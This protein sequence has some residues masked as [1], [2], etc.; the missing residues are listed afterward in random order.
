MTNSSV[1]RRQRNE[2]VTFTLQVMCEREDCD[3]IMGDVSQAAANTDGSIQ[4]EVIQGP[5]PLTNSDWS[6]IDEPVNFL[7]DMREGF[8]TSV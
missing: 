5:H 4:A 1:N 6:E 2:F 8:E 3:R 7:A